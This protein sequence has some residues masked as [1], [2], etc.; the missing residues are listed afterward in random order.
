MKFQFGFM[1]FKWLHVDVYVAELLD[2]FLEFR[3]AALL[4]D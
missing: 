1:G 4:V 3:R 2:G